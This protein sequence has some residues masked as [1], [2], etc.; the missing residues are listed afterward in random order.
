MKK[1]KE[2]TDGHQLQIGAHKMHVDK[3]GN[4]I[5]SNADELAKAS[6]DHEKT[7]Q[8]VKIIN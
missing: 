5:K 8:T 2:T 6:A 4:L 1:Q 3:N 7:K